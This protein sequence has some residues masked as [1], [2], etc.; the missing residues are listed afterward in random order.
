MSLPI[1]SIVLWLPA[2]GALL[3]LLV[4]RGADELAR[5]VA[6][7][8]A[9]A[10]FVVSLALP[11]GY[12]PADLTG[13][14]LAPELQFA[15]E[16]AWLPTWGISYSIGLDGVSLWLVLLTTF[17]TPV[18]VLSTWDSVH[19]EVRNF[20]ILLLLLTTAMM[21]VFVAQDLLLFY[22]FW[23]FT[24]IPMTFLIG[25][26]GGE[27]RIYA[28]RKFFIYT[29]AGSVLMLLAIIGIY[30]L[31]RQA[32]VAHDPNFVGSMNF[33]RIVSDLRSGNFTLETGIERMLFGAFFLAFAIKVPLW[34]FHTWLPDAHVE[35]PTAGSV[36]LAG[37]LLKLG[38]YGMIRY[39]ITLFPEASRWAAP[40]IAILA[41]IGIVYGAIVAFAQTDM[42]KLVAYSSVSHMGF[43]VLGIFALNMEGVS[44]AVLQM[45]NHGLSTGALF[46]IV[47]VLYERRHTREL[48]DYGGL[49]KIMPV[50]AAITLLVALSSAG[51]PGLNGFIGEFTIMQGAFLAPDLGWPFLGFAVLGVVLAAVYLFKMF[52]GVF[53]GELEPANA[54]LKDLSRREIA[55]LAILCVPIVLIGLY[56]AFIFNSMQVSV[57]EALDSLVLLAA[58]R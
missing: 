14:R 4:P 11:L 43:I 38:G 48:E 13:T 24:L 21:G 47:G 41:I 57:G 15:E 40:A 25:I 12:A 51:L 1:L 37:V 20:Q 2:L 17:L 31:H 5:R 8:V 29:F 36:V 16:L 10:T 30:V 53:M 7:G 50:Y 42:K 34:P 6:L 44:G 22:I 3:L 54:E 56:P 23:E 26:W 45:I 9:L 35:A 58:G 55:T 18:V 33:S 52:Q 19:K 32:L 27:N 46:L 39:C 28:A 49:W